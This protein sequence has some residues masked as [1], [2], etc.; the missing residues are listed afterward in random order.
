M[1]FNGFIA[2]IFVAIIIAYLFPEGIVL[3][4]LKT[5]TDIGI[6]FIF[7]FYGLKL[8]PAEFKLGF[9]NYKVH[10][11]IQL[12]TFVV[13]PL[14]ALLCL[15]L[16][17]TGTGS[18]LWIALFFLGTLPSTVSSSIVM[19]SLA[20]GNLP[21]AIFN[22][23]LS[24]LIGI[25][26]TPIWLSFFLSGNADFEFL[27]VL[28]KLCWQI[29]IPLIL[30]LF[31]QKFLGDFARKHSKKL[32][33]LDKTTIILIVY[34]SFSNS[35]T[36]NIFSSVETVDLLKLTAIVVLIFFVV[37]FGLNLICN[38]LGFDLKDKITT[39]FCGTKK[40]LVH[41]SVMVKVIFGNSANTGLLLLP[42]MI[43]HSLQLILIAFY[44]EKYRKRVLSVEA[45]EKAL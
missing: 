3:F 7:F 24:G 42:I 14:L 38:L 20:K 21:T 17:E 35:F 18:D 12:T 33:L 25:F 13:F 30:G 10:I 40:S 8:S 5:I 2:T 6:G 34:S 37:Y 36:S 44:A 22:A 19:V 26:A 27:D 32:G 39:Q 43:Y 16:F 29:I 4:P 23:S 45:S 28:I 41:G 15:P 1:K 9:L 31:L 11:V